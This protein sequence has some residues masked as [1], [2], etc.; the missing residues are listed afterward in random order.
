MFS[1]MKICFFDNFQCYTDV[2]LKSLVSKWGDFSHTKQTKEMRIFQ[3][4]KEEKHDSL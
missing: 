1:L 3:F 2:T 4:N